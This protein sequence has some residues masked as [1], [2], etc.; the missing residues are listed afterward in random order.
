MHMQSK[1]ESNYVA[2]N[3]W[4]ESLGDDMEDD[5]EDV[6][7]GDVQFSVK[8]DDNN[9]DIG[10]E[11]SPLTAS[12]HAGTIHHILHASCFVESSRSRTS[13]RRVARSRPRCDVQKE[14]VDLRMISDVRENVCMHVF[15][16]S[17]VRDVVAF[18]GI[19]E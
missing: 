6:Y 8:Y 10:L 18:R 11:A 4:L 2:A 7:V 15:E 5:T 14:V 17:T 16:F 3:A 9:N 19:A 12:T 13:R 1:N